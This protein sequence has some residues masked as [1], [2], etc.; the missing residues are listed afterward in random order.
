MA[1]LEY[2]FGAKKKKKIP[3]VS[4]GGE[5]IEGRQQVLVSWLRLSHGV[6]L[7]TNLFT[8]FLCI[9]LEGIADEED[10]L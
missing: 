5:R 9:I 3:I 1:P 6:A 8:D 4:N 10:S 7:F 2:E